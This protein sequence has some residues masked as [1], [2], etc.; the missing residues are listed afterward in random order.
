MPLTDDFSATIDYLHR[1]D[2]VVIVTPLRAGGEVPT[3]IWAV[4]V[5]GTPY[6]RSGYGPDAKWYQRAI[7][8]GRGAFV[9]YNGRRHDVALHRVHD[10]ELD[11][12][13]DRAYFD[14]YGQQGPTY[15]MTRDPARGTTLRVAP[16]TA[17]PPVS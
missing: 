4:T 2:T 13:V 15:S 12:D 7:R 14:K 5:D 1:N 6:I 8:T 11:V 17:Q 16:A 3:L 10:A 9:E